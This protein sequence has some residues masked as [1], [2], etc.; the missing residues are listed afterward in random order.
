MSSSSKDD[1]CLDLGVVSPQISETPVR[2]S[3]RQFMTLLVMVCLGFMGGLLV[4]SKTSSNGPVHVAVHLNGAP[5]G[6]HVVSTEVPSIERK[7]AVPAVTLGDEEESRLL[8]G[9]KSKPTSKPT[10]SPTVEPT[11]EVT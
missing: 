10:H 2:T 5:L 9:K 8:K 3:S 11:L 6:S 1:T 4:S 7:L